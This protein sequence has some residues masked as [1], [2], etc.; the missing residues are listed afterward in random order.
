MTPWFL[1]PLLRQ[2][3][4]RGCIGCIV[5]VLLYFD[6]PS[7]YVSSKIH[8]VLL[9]EKQTDFVKI[10]TFFFFHVRKCSFDAHFFSQSLAKFLKSSK[11]LTKYRIFAII[12]YNN[13]IKGI[14][15]VLSRLFRLLPVFL[16]LKNVLEIDYMIFMSFF[17]KVIVDVCYYSYRKRNIINCYCYCFFV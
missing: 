10:Q 8:V 9:Y 11:F 1:H 5:N 6:T 14:F 15:R 7:A 17:K 16:L 4:W 3:P 2:I 13:A 12:G